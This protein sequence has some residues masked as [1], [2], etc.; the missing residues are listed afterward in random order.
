M[1]SAP[2]LTSCKSPDFLIA[3]LIPVLQSQTGHPP[4]MFVQ[5][6]YD[7]PSAVDAAAGDANQRG[8][9][10]PRMQRS[11]GKQPPR[12]ERNNTEVVLFLKVTWEG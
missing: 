12:P 11:A 5:L 4:G 2:S 6:V 8:G 9:A 7:S 1:R 10:V 3:P